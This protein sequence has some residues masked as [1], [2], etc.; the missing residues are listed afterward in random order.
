MI[1]GLC[2]WSNKPTRRWA[3]QSVDSWIYCDLNRLMIRLWLHR[4]WSLRWFVWGFVCRRCI[5]GKGKCRGLAWRFLRNFWPLIFRPW[6]WR[7]SWLVRKWGCPYGWHS[8]LS[9]YLF[10][11]LRVPWW[12]GQMSWAWRWFQRLCFD[13]WVGPS[14]WYLSTWILPWRYLH[15]LSWHS[16]LLW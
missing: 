7:L 12:G 11:S 6:P 16:G 10:R 14:L 5:R 13:I 3:H 4:C 8:W 1:N 9:F 2:L 15:R